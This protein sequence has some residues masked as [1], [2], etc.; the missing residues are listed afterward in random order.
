MPL[1]RQRH[2]IAPDSLANTLYVN[3][4]S[5]DDTLLHGHIRHDIAADHRFNIAH[6]NFKSNIAQFL[7]EQ[8]TGEIGTASNN[9]AGASVG[10]I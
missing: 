3:R 1:L 8:P 5:G 6:I 2:P 7:Q 10:L 4:F 9:S